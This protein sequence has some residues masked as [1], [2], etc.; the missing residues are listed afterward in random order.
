MPTTQELY[1]QA[2]IG[3]INQ[4]NAQPVYVTNDSVVGGAT[5][6]NQV[7]AN[8]LLTSIDTKTTASVQRTAS[9]TTTT[10]AG[11][12]ALGA[13]RVTIANSGGASGVVDGETF[14]A[15]AIVSWE[16]PAKDTL[17]AITYNATGTTFLIAEV[18]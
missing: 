6:A 17:S 14:P 1:E 9:L 8:A 5:A 2:A 12:V 7:A 4:D 11:T 13:S 18:R 3:R 10:G 15:G 16:A